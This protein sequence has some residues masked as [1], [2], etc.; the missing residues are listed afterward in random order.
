MKKFIISLITL[1]L[2]VAPAA[3]GEIYGYDETEDIMNGV[4]LRHIRRFYGDGW[5]NINAVVA[6]LKEPNVKL[7][8]LKGQNVDSLTSMD[9]LVSGGSANEVMAASNADFFD[10]TKPAYSQGFSLGLEVKDSR[11]LQSQVDEN[12]AAAF[13]DGKRLN[14]SYMSM[15]MTLTAPNGSSEV[16]RHLNKHTD[17]YGEILMYT[18]DWNNGLSPAPGGEVVEVVVRN[19][20]VTEFR[21]NMPPVEIPKD[22]Y[23][24]AVSEGVNMFLANNLTV[25]SHLELSITATPS[26]EGV[27]AAFG[28]GTLLLKD[29]V[30]TE[31]THVAYGNQP[32]TCVGTNADGTVVYIITVDGRQYQSKG[33]TQEGLADITL[34]LGCV[35]ALNLDGGGSTRLM[36]KT[37][38]DNETKVVNLPTEN[39]KVINAVSITTDAKPGPAAGVRLRAAD[40][41]ALVG[42]IF[43][44]EV[45]YVDENGLAAAS[46]DGEA[47]FSVYGVEAQFS[48]TDFFPLT[49]GDAVITAGLEGPEGAGVMSAPLNVHVISQVSAIGLPQEIELALGE[50]LWLTPDVSGDGYTAAVHN[51]NLLS[52]ATS[53]P[54]VASYSG[55]LITGNSEGYTLLTLSYG[56]VTAHSIVKV[57]KPASNAPAL[58]D[59]DV[60]DQAKGAVEGQSFSVFAD[61]KVRNTLFDNL[62]YRTGMRKIA[63]S[64]SYGFLGD[65]RAEALPS[66]LRVPIQANSFSAI[67]KGFAL[68]IS[69]PASGQLSASDWADMDA[70]IK[71]TAARAVIVL[72]KTAPNGK[73]AQD[74]ELFYDY[75]DSLSKCKDVYIVQPGLANNVTLR[76]NVRLI[77]VSDSAD[78]DSIASSL[79]G[80]RILR[81]TFG[82]GGSFYQFE[83]LFP[84]G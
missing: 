51:P 65:Y 19:D 72:T 14:F 20:T 70:A 31:F 2:I 26:L 62:L 48:G 27:E 84:I 28:G 6:D 53:D 11:L 33:V 83:P 8:L 45:R 4:Q 73:I 76:N 79:S 23:V 66:G 25:G 12:M 41:A 13:Y 71:A 5:L 3:F 29:G 80:S 18:S 17:Y 82:D 69:L 64:D 9:G 1:L 63:L 35:N 74:T 30:R 68:I 60:L 21:R 75:F 56:G 42:D 43:P 59:N 52:P 22:G 7:E 37:F 81:F 36:A 55:G 10:N 54:T 78:Y 16:V 32:R 58:P 44:I 40:D 77:T 46:Q 57:G 50:S 34:E 61:T 24:L 39:R 49:A 38:W 15:T 67:D 47:K